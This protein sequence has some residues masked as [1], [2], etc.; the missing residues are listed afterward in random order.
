MSEIVFDAL[1]DKLLPIGRERVQEKQNEFLP[2]AAAMT[3]D[4]EIKYVGPETEKTFP[5][6]PDALQ[7]LNAGLK[8][9]A[10]EGRI[11]ASAVV[12]SVE[13]KL[14]DAQEESDAIRFHLEFKDGAASNVYLPF[15]IDELTG[16]VSWGE[17]FELDAESRVFE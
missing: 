8:R 17:P 2:F 15:D 16:D 4:N 1:L 3:P 12:S 9:M 6:P 5:S 13:V 11:E 14:P 7:Y 10:S